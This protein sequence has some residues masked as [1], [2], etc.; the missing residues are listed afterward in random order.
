MDVWMMQV[1]VLRID[2]LTVDTANEPITSNFEWVGGTYAVGM[3]EGLMLYVLTAA[4]CD[5]DLPDDL[6]KVVEW[7][8]DAGHEWIRFDPEGDIEPSLPLYDWS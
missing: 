8:H 2:H 5:L 6:R 7:A 4:E 1:R 3:P